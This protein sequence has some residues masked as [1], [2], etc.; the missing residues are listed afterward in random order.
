MAETEEIQL[1]FESALCAQT[2]GKLVELSQHFKIEISPE[3]KSKIQIIKLIREHVEDVLKKEPAAEQMTGLEFLKDAI[4]FLHDE[5]PELEKDETGKE[6]AQLEKVYSE[7]KLKH[8]QELSEVKSKLSGLKKKSET[9]P[10]NEA[11]GAGKSEKNEPINLEHQVKKTVPTEHVQLKREFKISGQIGEPG[12]NEKLSFISL[13][14]QIDLGLKRG[15]AEADIIDS[16]IRSISPH[17]N[18]RSYI[19]ML[20]DLSLAK[21][22]KLLRLHYRE[23]TA[24]DLYKELSVVCQQAK[25]TPEKFLIRALNLRNKVLFASQEA[26]SKFEYG[27][28]LIQNTFLKALETGLRDDILVTNLRP[29]LRKT[30][31]SDEDLIQQVNELAS[32]QAERQSKLG[33]ERQK[34]AKVNAAEAK[35]NPAP[36]NRNTQLEGQLLA[37]IKEIKSDL[38]ALKS[39]VHNNRASSYQARGR[40][41][42][43]PRG[44]GRG[45]GYSAPIASYRR[46]CAQCESRG[47]GHSCPH[48]FVC[49]SEGHFRSKCPELAAPEPQEN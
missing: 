48:C 26:D 16:I 2:V 9:P 20:P 39:E 32:N 45:R 17:S 7:L 23:K 40:G 24:S 42:G 1:E 4:H 10:E 41:R 13:T 5:P 14:H 6:I 35:V 38:S 8:E 21:L 25:E 19:E 44:R 12:Q 3:V 22:R 27:L 15:Y 34:Q 30:D 29:V 43:R 37:E 36:V 49:G 28:S 18:L 46:G 11:K 31:L 33:A 47:I